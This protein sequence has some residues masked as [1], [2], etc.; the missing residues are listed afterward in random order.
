MIK[1]LWSHGKKSLRGMVENSTLKP[2]ALIP[3]KEFGAIQES[4]SEDS[5]HK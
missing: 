3:E 4:Q 1:I 2:V 5:L